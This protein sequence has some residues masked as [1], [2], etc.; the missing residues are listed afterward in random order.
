MDDKKKEKKKEKKEK[1]EKPVTV[2]ITNHNTFQKGVGAFV[3]NLNHL[4]IVMDSEG[5]MKLDAGQV[6]VMPHTQVDTEEEPAQDEGAEDYS[7][8]VAKCFKFAN[9]YVKQKLRIIVSNYYQGIAANLALIEVALFDHNLLNKRNAHTALLKA[10]MA[11]DM[12]DQLSDEEL[13]KT[14]NGMANKLGFLP[15]AG[16][17]EWYDKNYVNDKKTCMD[18]A[19]RKKNNPSHSSHSKISFF[20]ILSHSSHSR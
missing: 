1:K 18:I 7:A 5:N 2:H 20:L 14:R 13:K 19:G 3:T 12:I 9:D 16:Y 10:L 8:Y 15:S 11:W 6:P 17:M 4:T